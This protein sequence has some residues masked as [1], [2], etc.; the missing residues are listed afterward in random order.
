MKQFMLIVAALTISCAIAIAHTDF[1]AERIAHFKMVGQ[2][3]KLAS[4]MIRQER[5]FDVVRAR[6]AFKEM[7]EH[8]R[9]TKSL[10]PPDSLGGNSTA[11]PEI[12]KNRKDYD[13]RLDHL[14]RHLEEGEAKITDMATL[15]KEWQKVSPD[16]G[17]C[18]KAYR[19][20]R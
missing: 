16:C 15:Q 11:S 8:L 7:A 6:A 19:T 17:G 10:I 3:A 12:W 18:H 20:K 1:V 14:I 5:P 4:D 13:S 9:K 2:N